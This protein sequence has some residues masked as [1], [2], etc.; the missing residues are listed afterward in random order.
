MLMNT[1]VKPNGFL[2]YMSQYPT[3]GG[4]ATT[5]PMIA[6][7]FNFQGS[8]V[9]FASPFVVAVPSVLMRMSL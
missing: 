8:G 1:E 6:L 3:S 9:E 4:D 5:S 2:R 7:G